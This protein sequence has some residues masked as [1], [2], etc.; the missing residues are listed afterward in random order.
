VSGGPS[1]PSYDQAGNIL[2]DN[3]GDGNS[4]LY[5]AEGRICAAQTPAVDGINIWTGYVYD[6]EG[7]RV[8][9]GTITSW[10]CDSST[11]GFGASANETDYVLDQSGHQVT[12]MASDA[13][14]TMAWAH[15]NVWAGG[16][17]IATYSAITDANG[18]ADGALHF[19]FNDWLGTRRIQTDYAG[20]V[21]QTCA[22]L[23][24][25]D[26]KSCA[27][28]PTE[29]LFTGKERDSE[30][31]N[32]YFG[33]RYYASSMGRF[34]SPDPVGG[35]LS[36]PQS[37]NRYA[38]VVNN[39]LR[40]VDPTGLDCVYKGDNANDSMVVR[41]DCFSD[42]DDGVFVDGHV[43]S[44]YDQGRNIWANVS[45]YTDSNDPYANGTN[46][47]IYLPGM[48]D[49]WNGSQIAQQVFQG[50][51]SG[52][53]GA[54]N[55]AVNYAA[56]GEALLA[57]GAFFA[58][59]IAAGVGAGTSWAA[60]ASG[61]LGPAAGRVFWSAIGSGA[62]AEWAEQ[63]GGSTLEMTPLG[64]VANWAQ[65]YLPQNG[66]TGAAWNALSSGFASG[67]QG[68]VT[69]LQGARLGSTWLNTELP[70]LEQQGNPIITVPVP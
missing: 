1:V 65:G 15:T 45:G 4:Y 66:F 44:L 6:A 52:A 20:V 53:F 36:N 9:K 19:Y 7:R 41:G 23:P 63:N 60:N 58:P 27:P 61:A 47:Q 39:P 59:E 3:N 62:A 68:S 25:G 55:T 2:S 8:A 70:I 35:S 64:S 16:Q 51:G 56:G 5:D 22:S 18:Q 21:E 24:Y 40:N 11:N 10:S 32:D 38:Y 30:S 43:D 26:Q 28:M 34:M 49:Q 42:D 69:Y 33:A 54:A 12:E 13:N 31:G 46:G 14:G 37:L 48:M 29:N 50:P 57:G 17:L 67:A